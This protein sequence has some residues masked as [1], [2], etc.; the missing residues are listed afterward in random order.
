MDNDELNLEEELAV[1]VRSG[2]LDNLLRKEGYSRYS[3]VFTNVIKMI[4]NTACN[5]LEFTYDAAENVLKIHAKVA[6]RDLSKEHDTYVHVV[7]IGTEEKER[8]VLSKVVNIFRSFA[9]ST[10][11]EIIADIKT[12]MEKGDGKDD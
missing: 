2:K 1:L 7:D 4:N 5:A 6:V 10:R 8:D 9:D 12:D 11:K 3:S